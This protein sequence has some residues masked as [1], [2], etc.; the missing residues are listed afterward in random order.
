VFSEERS[1]AH[2]V[3]LKHS[4]VSG[5]REITMDGRPVHLSKKLNMKTDFDYP[6]DVPG[7]LMRVSIKETVDRFVYSLFIDNVPFRHLPH[8]SE[9]P[10]IT[11]SKKKSNKK[12]G[13]S[14]SS[15]SSWDPFADAGVDTKKKS[16][17]K[18]KKKKSKVKKQASTSDWVDF[19]DD[20]ATSSP[21][22]SSSSKKKKESS[23]AGDLLADVFST[24]T[25]ISTPA[26]T[27]TSGDDLF[28]ST[29][30]D[31]NDLSS[32]YAS[33]G[34][35]TTNTMMTTQ[36]QQ[37]QQRSTPTIQHVAVKKTDSWG[38]LVDLNGITA[39][40]T[41]PVVPTTST[42]TTTTGA[43]SITMNAF[44][45]YNMSKVPTSYMSPS[46]PRGGMMMGGGYHQSPGMLPPRSMQFQNTLPTQ[47]PR[48]MSNHRKVAAATQS[49][50]SAFEADPFARFN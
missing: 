39:Q 50:A 4:I 41:P 17:S 12:K 3:I 24:S 18:K 19:G 28:S 35:P 29:G 21:S 10:T 32:L 27:T 7:H 38:G 8:N 15:S 6:W 37:Q 20:T 42:T 2:E 44:N 33:S 43:S 26:T 40:Q 22:S 14:S 49:P 36:Q 5:K 25:T 31:L 11:P 47:N 30:A 13:G 9:V 48:A 1:E 23:S 45:S 16:S 46:Q 34:T